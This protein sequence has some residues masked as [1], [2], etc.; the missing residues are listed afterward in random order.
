[1]STFSGITSA[2]SALQAQRQALDITGENI[3]NAN[4]DGYTRQRVDFASAGPSAV[5]ATYATPGT[6]AGGVTVASVTRMQDAYLE[7]QG[8]TEHAQQSLLDGSQ[9]IVND[10]Q[11]AFN[12]PSDTG[13]QAQ[14]SS[15]WSAFTD[16]ANNPG[17]TAA[18]NQAL[19]QATTVASTLNSDYTTLAGQYADRRN[20]LDSTVAQVNADAAT[21]AKLNAAVVA[22][23]QSG[24]SANELADQR[25]SVAMQLVELTGATA[26]QAQN[27]SVT[28]QLGGSALVAGS[29]ARSLAVTGSG[30]LAGQPTSP[31]TVQ[32]ADTGT[33]ASVSSGTIGAVL[34]GL[35]TT[36]PRYASALDGVAAN[37]ANSVNQVQEAGFTTSGVQGTALF[38]GTTAATISVAI[39]GPAGIAASSSATQALDG[40]NADALAQIGQ[41]PTG[42]DAQYR[43]VVAQLGTA[44]QT[45]TQA[46]STQDSI[47][48]QVDSQRSSASGVNIDEELTGMLTYQ[49]AYEAAS[50][51]MAT[52][53]SMLDTLIN[54]T[55]A[56]S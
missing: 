15:L 34:Q 30:T 52:A 45:A 40:G 8:R 31:V 41:S 23:N 1:M 54:R 48:A 14:L 5:P 56:G 29:T 21:L 28:L 11:Q 10:V 3:A 4:T 32:W 12:E 25:D 7:A 43:T 38:S 39:T 20:Q 26:T 51:V 35:G 17:D 22:A 6:D 18:R 55:G 33:A 47:T 46:A 37:L 44:V 49:R 19:S 27:G 24:R 42:P 13:L 50:K 2:L 36:I 16:V 53:D 9:Q